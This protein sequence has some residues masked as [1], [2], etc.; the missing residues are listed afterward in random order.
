MNSIS[1]RRLVL[2]L[3]FLAAPSLRAQKELVPDRDHVLRE[4]VNFAPHD[5]LDPHR[6]FYLDWDPIF[7]CLYETPLVCDEG[8]EIL[9]LKPRLLRELPGIDEDGRSMR[10]VFR[11]D[12]RFHDDPCFEGGK[13]RLLGAAD[14]AFVLA[15]HIDPRS[16]SPYYLPYL[17]GRILGAREARAKAEA[18]GVFDYD[19]PIPGIEVIGDHELVI[20]FTA[21][22]PRFAALLTMTWCA[23][24]PR[25]AWTRYG[26]GLA[27]HPVGTGPYLYDR[28][29]SRADLVAMRPNPAYW[30]RA[31]GGALGALPLNGGVRF[32]VL[33]DLDLREKRFLEEDLDLLDLAPTRAANFLDARHGLRAPIRRKGFALHR[34]DAGNLHYVAF[35]MKNRILAKPE[36]R[37]ALALAIDRERFIEEFYAGAARPADHLVPPSLPFGDDDQKL[38]W[39]WGRHDP[40]RARQ[41]L[42]EAGYPEGKGL[43]EFILSRWGDDEMAKLETG[44]LADCWR[45]IGVK[46]QVR[47][48]QGDEFL[49]RSR[50]GLHEISINYWVADYP[51]PDNFFMML[52]KSSWPDPAKNQDSPNAG[53]WTDERY[54]RLYEKAAKLVPGPERGR[55][56]TEMAKLAQTEVPWAFLAH[57]ENVFL[58]AP[59]I[60]G[61]ASRSNFSR[62]YSRI[63]KMVKPAKN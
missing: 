7:R 50:Q 21:P 14:F 30:N 46:V 19:A 22:N 33:T 16:Q 6:I 11:D 17:D 39:T 38:D 47:L 29:G 53:F 54:E 52:L 15:R 36:V 8:S 59:G 51:D 48:E 35:N 4:A 41:L 1:S 25:E 34:A 40:E 13:G 57:G 9:R 61:L 23:L 2:A 60:E 12:V 49:R 55:L 20:R 10:L 62:D 63:R 24:I 5:R 32:E 26:D 44:I 31:A 58:T 18:E 42:A 28:E 43:P 37:R 3:L 45:E 56:F 27:Q